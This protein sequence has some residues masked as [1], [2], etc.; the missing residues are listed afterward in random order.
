M[1]WL[2]LATLLSI[3]CAEQPTFD[4]PSHID[5][6][7]IL[8][9]RANPPYARPGDHVELEVLAVDGRSTAPEPMHV[10]FL[11]RPCINP[12]NDAYY[13]CFSDFHAEI[14]SGVDLESELLSGTTFSFDMPTDVIDAHTGIPGQTPYGMVVVFAIACAGR[15]EYRPDLA[16]AAPDAVPF[17]CFDR[18]DGQLGAQ[19]FAFAYF[20]SQQRQSAAREPHLRRHSRRL[21]R[22]NR[23]RPLY[24]FEHRRLPRDQARRERAE[25]VP[26][27]R[28][29]Q[30]GSG[31][32]DS[33]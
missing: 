4:A 26:R 12:P 7:R 8:A 19:D 23:G 6:V 24:G 32:R 21:R 9:T 25:L 29:E 13:G 11:P 15:V 16:G 33:G 3:S 22:R 18:S 17:V 5:S 30:L 2:L 10:Y 20:R 27:A 1:R 31:R 28:S 14:P